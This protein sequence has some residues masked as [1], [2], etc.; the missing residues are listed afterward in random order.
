MLH[1]N[2]DIYKTYFTNKRPLPDYSACIRFYSPNLSQFA[3]NCNYG[4]QQLQ[5]KLQFKTMHQHFEYVTMEI[6]N[7][8]QISKRLGQIAQFNR[9]MIEDLNRFS[10]HC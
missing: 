9:T 10:K 4:Q 7:K 2:H 1:V 5:T 6:F 3:S 8:I